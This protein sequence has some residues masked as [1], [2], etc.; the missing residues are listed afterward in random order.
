MCKIYS[1]RGKGQVTSFII[2]GIVIL[3][4]AGTIFYL[5]QNSFEDVDVLDYSPEDLSPV[6]S[7]L[8]SCLEDSAHRALVIVGMQGGYIDLPGNIYTSPKNYLQTSVG[9]MKVPLW[10][11]NGQDI[12][13]DLDLVESQMEDFIEEDIKS[14]VNQLEEME[15]VGDVIFN[16]LPSV[17]ASINRND[18]S[19][20]L[21]YEF[22]AEFKNKFITYDKFG[23]RLPVKLYDM[24]STAAYLMQRN[25]EEM[26]LAY[27]T[28][29]ILAMDPDIPLGDMKFDCGKL[30][31]SKRAVQQKL[32][33]YLEQLA[34][35]IRVEGTDFMSFSE[36]LKVYEKFDSEWDFE[37]FEQE[38]MPD[39]LPDD[40][41]EYLHH[42]WRMDRDFKGLNVGFSYDEKYGMEM[43]VSPSDGDRIDAEAGRSNSKYLQYLCF[44][45]YH[46]T[47]DISYP[48]KV[49][50]Y[51]STAFSGDGYSFSFGMPIFIEKNIPKTTMP[52]FFLMDA[53]ETD[54][55]F[56]RESNQNVNVQA[57]DYFTGEY[58]SNVEITYDCTLLKCDLGTISS[59]NSYNL[60]MLVSAKVPAG[61]SNGFFIAEKPG[62]LRVKEQSP[63]ESGSV[64][65]SMLPLKEFNFA[66]SQLING[67]P[68]PYTDEYRATIYIKSKNHDFEGFYTY[69]VLPGQTNNLHLLKG[70]E[71]YELELYLYRDDNLVGGYIGDFEVDY[72]DLS[73]SRIDFY[74]K[75]FV[76]MARG[77]DPERL[78]SL[79]DY[80]E[81]NPIDEPYR[82]KYYP[83]FR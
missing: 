30:R 72:D 49:T 51:D 17:N 67:V 18:V 28:V 38:G 14:C 57:K 44:N 55:N 19:F 71:T 78:L 31:W 24:L 82:Q 81:E 23:V 29:N 53:R 7:Y 56:C 34:P 66:L 77:A 5:R 74:A 10:R 26:F 83:Q 64:E 69:P 25:T 16:T 47:Y 15:Y 76:D 1:M 46:F 60:P 2:V 43:Q 33:G 27:T 52:N 3:L 41:Y 54:E 50:L 73:S 68:E 36:P 13:P 8:V 20:I 48:L 58:L 35:T 9:G 65:L 59:S 79:Y 6:E 61:C 42:F 62:Y 32:Q 21:D 11:V 40:M 70:P 22:E 75:E 45:V 12:F 63:V 37:R 39:N 80:L 4:I